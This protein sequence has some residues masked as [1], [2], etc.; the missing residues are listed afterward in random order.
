MVITDC[1]K[2]IAHTDLCDEKECLD[3]LL[4]LIKMQFIVY[5]WIDIDSRKM[6]YAQ[7]CIL[8]DL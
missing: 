6:H 7:C 5:I 3:Y 4:V 8:F 2:S 1:D